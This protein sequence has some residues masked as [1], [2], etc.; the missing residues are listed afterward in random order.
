MR[1]A[2]DIVAQQDDFRG[3]IAAVLVDFCQEAGEQILAPV[4][5]AD[6]V[7]QLICSRHVPGFALQATK[8]EH[9][10]PPQAYARIVDRFSDMTQV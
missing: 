9:R 8:T 1:A 5:I 2:I 3:G 6:R 4:H 7:D 10:A